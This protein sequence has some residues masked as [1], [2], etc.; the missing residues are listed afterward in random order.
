MTPDE[1]FSQQFVPKLLN[2]LKSVPSMNVVMIPSLRDVIHPYF[3]YPQ[4][5]LEKARLFGANFTDKRVAPLFEVSGILS[6]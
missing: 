5:P 1:I 4:P 2:M 3:V 6:I